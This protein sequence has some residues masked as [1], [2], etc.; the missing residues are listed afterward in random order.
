MRVEMAL[1]LNAYQNPAPPGIPPSALQFPYSE[2]VLLP[3]SAT[4]WGGVRRGPM[5]RSTRG[6]GSWPR[7]ARCTS[8]WSHPEEDVGNG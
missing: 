5:A 2:T 4:P 1:L 8:G 7:F 3:Y 6:R